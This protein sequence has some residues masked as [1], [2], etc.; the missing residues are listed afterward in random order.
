MAWWVCG[1]Y[2]AANLASFACMWRDKLAAA[3]GR[4]R[5]PEA[6]LLVL[7][8]L[9]GGIGLLA[10]MRVLHHKTRRPNFWVVGWLALAAHL[11]AWAVLFVRQ[12]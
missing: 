5:T 6:R 9:A 2:A 4:R 10:S 8:V 12:W 3:R 7:G 1:I 11:A